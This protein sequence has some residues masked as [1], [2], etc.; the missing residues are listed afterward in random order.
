M[1]GVMREDEI[2]FR[3]KHFETDGFELLSEELAR[4]NN[5]PRAALEICMVF[6]GCY[7]RRNGKAIQWV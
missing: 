3:G 4:F 2:R 1:S 7:R 6:Y 5:F